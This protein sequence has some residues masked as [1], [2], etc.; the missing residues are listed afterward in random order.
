M[1][2][3]SHCTPDCL[4][5]HRYK[6]NQSRHVHHDCKYLLLPLLVCHHHC[7]EKV[8]IFAHICHQDKLRLARVVWSTL[9]LWARWETEFKLKV[10]RVFSRRFPLQTSDRVSVIFSGPLRA[11]LHHFV[12][13]D[14][15][16]RLRASEDQT[17][18]SMFQSW[19]MFLDDCFNPIRE[20]HFL[21]HDP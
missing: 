3:S 6:K 4:I 17:V 14:H 11:H 5:L 20:L 12:R 9:V 18:M 13:A 2:R 1:I 19:D 21:A 10:D 16:A 7:I 8:I 15:I